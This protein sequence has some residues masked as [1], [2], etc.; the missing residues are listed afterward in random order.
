[1]G[2]D[3]FTGVALQ[4]MLGAIEGNKTN[5]P[6]SA[7]IVV[8]GDD[9]A[10]NYEILTE[11]QR[12]CLA[13]I[14]AAVA[15]GDIGRLSAA[16]ARESKNKYKNKNNN[17]LAGGVCVHVADRRGVTPLATAVA[18]CGGLLR[19]A[20]TIASCKRDTAAVGIGIGVEVVEPDL[21]RH[22]ACIRALV[23]EHDVDVVVDSVHANVSSS[24]KA[25]RGF[26]ALT[27]AAGNGDVATLNLLLD[28]VSHT[29]TQTHMIDINDSFRAFSVSSNSSR[30]LV[31]I[32]YF[33]WQLKKRAAAKAAAGDVAASS[34]SAVAA[35]L[36]FAVN[37][38]SSHHGVTPLAA[39]AAADSLPCVEL[40]IDA[41]ADAAGRILNTNGKS[42]AATAVV[43]AH[44]SPLR[45]AAAYGSVDVFVAVAAAALSH[46]VVSGND[47][48]S[49]GGAGDGGS[50]S[51]GVV[52][53]TS[54]SLATAAFRCAV[55]GNNVAVVV[56]CL[57]SEH[58]GTSVALAP[59]L[60]PGGDD[61][62]GNGNNDVSGGD[63]GGGND[64]GSGGGGD[65]VSATPA[66]LAAATRL[67]GGAAKE[68]SVMEAA[69]DG[70]AVATYN[71]LLKIGVRVSV[72]TAPSFSKVMTMTSSSAVNSRALALDNLDCI[73]HREFLLLASWCCSCCCLCLL[74]SSV[75]FRGR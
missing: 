50:G 12:D 69:V 33:E 5:T 53:L 40:L 17:N 13:A 60:L 49:S 70:G 68:A 4:S 67:C 19:T 31:P 16:V 72:T 18:A 55:A 7:T 1:M 29:R 26:S 43:F 75:V 48:S 56:H 74:L 59:P 71:L 42:N 41:G 35:A 22:H 73:A 11:A 24:C 44:E 58:D 38:S 52:S 51:D 10:F 15:D 32:S 2:T 23:D 66:F 25:P 62:D 36:R 27:L 21:S 54:V 65:G 64:N 57:K 8:D 9:D 39:A 28:L 61:A 63:K 6:S 37:V 46:G 47:G 14:H 20:A 45:A 30:V 3:V 34:S